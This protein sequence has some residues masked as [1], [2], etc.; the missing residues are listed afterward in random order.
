MTGA[1]AF[2]TPTGGARRGPGFSP[3][4]RT[5]LLRR[6]RPRARKPCYEPVQECPLRD[7]WASA[8]IASRLRSGC[9]TKWSGKGVVLVRTG[10]RVL[11]TSSQ[12]SQPASR[13]C[14]QSADVIHPM[15]RDNDVRE[16]SELSP[17]QGDAPPGLQQRGSTLID[18]F[19]QSEEGNTE[20]D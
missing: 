3:V 7:R 11:K 16:A 12:A 4:R 19:D 14:D 6:G 20:R 15:A 18:T 10:P 17:S 1:P 2:W 5:A 9:R 13:L 8:A